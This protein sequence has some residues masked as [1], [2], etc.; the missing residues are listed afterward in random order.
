MLQGLPRNGTTE[1]TP[2]SVTLWNLSGNQALSGGQFARIDGASALNDESM[3]SDK[4]K[5]IEEKI[6]DLKA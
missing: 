2:L 1:L 3:N 6:A 5:E 4:I